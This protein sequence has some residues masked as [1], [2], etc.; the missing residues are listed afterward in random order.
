MLNVVNTISIYILLDKDGNIRYV[1]KSINPSKR[2]WYHQHGNFK[3]WVDSFQI[4]ETEIPEDSWKQREKFWIEFY[5]K[6]GCL[7]EN[8]CE[9]GNGKGYGPGHTELTKSKIGLS[10]TGKTHVLSEESRNKISKSLTG[11]KYKKKELPVRVVRLK[12][13][14]NYFME[15]YRVY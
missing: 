12:E 2:F 5:R 8:K 11:M 13:L 3:D 7:L 15:L 4:I 14:N 10:N 9:G 1:G 6:Q